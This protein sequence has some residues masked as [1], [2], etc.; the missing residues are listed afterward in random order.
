M[1]IDI[2][3]FYEHETQNYFHLIQEGIRDAQIIKTACFQKYPVY[4]VESEKFC[5]VD[6]KGL[7]QAINNIESYRKI[8]DKLQLSYI[9]E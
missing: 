5:F 3:N 1:K 9:R 2:R 8:L 4:L 7:H 6:L